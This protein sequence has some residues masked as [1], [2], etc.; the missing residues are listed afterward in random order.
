MEYIEIGT[1]ANT[2]GVK[3]ALKVKTDSDFKSERYKKGNI[4]YIKEKQSFLPLTV[5]S[6]FTKGSVDIVTFKGFESINEVEKYKG[7]TLYVK[8]SD[9]QSLEEDTFYFDRLIGLEVYQSDQFVGTVSKVTEVPQGELLRVKREDL[10]DALIPFTKQF[11]LNVSLE[12]NRI[13]IVDLEGLL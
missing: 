11:V 9:R 12:N 8:D 4:L 6:Y 13:D 1:I 3:G 7:Q 10:K 5:E 2:H